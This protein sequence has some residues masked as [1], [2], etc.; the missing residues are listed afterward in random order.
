M[1]FGPF[2][3]YITNHIQIGSQPRLKNHMSKVIHSYLIIKNIPKIHFILNQQGSMNKINIH[4]GWLNIG[5]LRLIKICWPLFPSD[6]FFNLLWLL[7]SWYFLIFQS[8][9][10]MH[11]LQIIKNTQLDIGIWLYITCWICC[12]AFRLKI[13]YI[14]FSEFF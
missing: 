11:N 4:W 14:H 12:V 13:T 10:W 6:E 7:L 2:T 3:V 1:W 5:E 9:L 8:F